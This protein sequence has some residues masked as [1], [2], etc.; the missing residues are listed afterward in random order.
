MYTYTENLYEN[1]IKK[2]A[3]KSTS[4][5]IITGYASYHFV[6]KILKEFP[7]L[8]IC[9]FIGMSLQGIPKE[10]H[11][12]YK[13]LMQKYNIKIYYQIYGANTHIKAYKFVGENINEVLVGSAN[14]TENGFV[15]NNELLTNINNGLNNL[16]VDQEKRS[17]L[18]TDK[19]ILTY[20]QLVDVGLE[21]DPLTT[22]KYIND[23]K[24][25]ENKSK[26]NELMKK[27][28]PNYYNR[29]NFNY[30]S[31]P[32]V[33][34]EKANKNW[35]KEGINSLFN[36]LKS[37]PFLIMN[38]KNSKQLKEFLPSNERFVVYDFNDEIL[39]CEL[40]GEFNRELHFLNVNI[41]DYIQNILNLN[42]TTPITYNHLKYLGYH[43]ITFKKINDKEYLMT[44][45]KENIRG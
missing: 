13:K 17:M 19:S 3:S 39:N 6:E 21:S 38:N 29:Y 44:L 31:V 25:L 27:N 2:N 4:F 40:S 34:D 5:K 18:C 32:I 9:L 8:T 11:E 22:N 43:F 1:V 12:G 36:G 35:D 15:N 28:F 16:F 42:E 20:I 41:Y 45:S 24:V 7:K 26:I 30:I 23:N 14:F 33:V 10:D 37:K